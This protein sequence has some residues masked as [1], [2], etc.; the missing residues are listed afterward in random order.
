MITPLKYKLVISDFDGTLLRDDNTISSRTVKAI[1]KFVDMGGIFTVSTGRMCNSILARLPELGLDKINIPLMGYQGA[2]IIDNLTGEVLFERNISNADAV[3]LV[4]DCKDQNLYHQVYFAPDRLVTA[5]LNWISD[6]Y[7]K[8]VGVTAE[9]VGDLEEYL[10]KTKLDCH[11]VLVILEPERAREV[12]KGFSERHVGTTAFISHP[13][14]VEMVSQEA[15]KGNAAKWAAEKLG[16]TMEEIIGI[17]DSFN[18]IPLVETAGRGIAVANAMPE[19][20]AVAD[21][22]SEYNNNEDAVARIL[23]EII[24]HG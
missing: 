4:R 17:G 14:F 7:C 18:D 19:L 8:A 20:K 22:V 2:R 23:E 3:K 12:M 1:K 11:K 24:L 9:G 6:K 16:I 5:E 21:E 10:I 15:G 13:Y